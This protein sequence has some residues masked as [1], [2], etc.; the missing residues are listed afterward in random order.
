MKRTTAFATLAALCWLGLSASPAEDAIVP[1]GATNLL[2][3]K[4]FTGWKLY[5]PGNADVTKTWSIKD[6]V[7]ACTGKPAGYM[8]TENAYRD[9]KLTV[10]W[11]FTRA[12]NTGV[13]L[14]MSGPDKV[15]PR[16]IE[17]QGLHE[18][19]GD[20]FVIDGTEF[21]EHRGVEGRRVAKKGPSNEKPAGEWNT[22]EI[23]CKG[24]GI[25]VFVNGKLM[26]EATECNVSSG[27]ICIQS[28]GGEIE[29]RKV[30]VEPAGT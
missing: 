25:R 18:N 16:S 1:T 23:V 22:Y 19:Q 29:I 5:L 13:L 8:R 20:F 28:E 4:D 9:Y 3:G 7:V 26:N 14:H 11:R 2:N 21:K 10:E 24:T 12:G 6:G 15:W 27:K 30:L 17:A